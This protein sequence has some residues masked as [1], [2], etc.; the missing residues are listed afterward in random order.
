MLMEDVGEAL[1]LMEGMLK[2]G[3]STGQQSLAFTNSMVGQGIKS[4]RKTVF[5]IV[6]R[7]N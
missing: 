3:E 7:H 5:A 1:E 2:K 6:Y 4:N